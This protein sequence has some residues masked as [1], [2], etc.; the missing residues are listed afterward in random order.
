VRRALRI[1]GVMITMIVLILAG[2][3]VGNSI[4]RSRTN[5]QQITAICRTINLEL[6]V[7]RRVTLLQRRLLRGI[8]L[9]RHFSP[10]LLNFSERSFREILVLVRPRKC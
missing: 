7:L 1:L 5:A 4:S 8:A 9:D 6:K 10:A 3:E 2:V